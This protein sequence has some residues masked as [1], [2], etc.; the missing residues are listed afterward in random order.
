MLDLPK[1]GKLKTISTDLHDTVKQIQSYV[2]AFSVQMGLDA[3]RSFPA[4]GPPQQVI[5]SVAAATGLMQVSIVDKQPKGRLINYFVDY[6]NNPAFTNAI[7]VPMQATRTCR[8]Y[9]GVGTYY[10]RAY[11]QYFGS[12]PSQKINVGGAVP[13]PLVVAG[14]VPPGGGVPQGSGGGNAG[15]GGF[16]GTSP[17]DQG[18]AGQ[19]QELLSPGG[20][21]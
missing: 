5:A 17:F 15:G 4:P 7:T 14:E 20:R 21:G 12:N 2:N 11:S 10:V 3:N 1:L 13:T 8:M 6:A 18:D 16:G 19:P 9:L